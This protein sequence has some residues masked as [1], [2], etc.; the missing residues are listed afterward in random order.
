[1]GS[2]TVVGFFFLRL[3]CL[4]KEGVHNILP[5]KFLCFENVFVLLCCHEILKANFWASHL[6]LQFLLRFDM[7]K[8]SKDTQVLVLFMFSDIFWSPRI[9]CQ[10]PLTLFAYESN[11]CKPSSGW[12]HCVFIT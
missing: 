11:D 3:Y 7:E 6:F 5:I 1:M 9:F 8:P 10:E 4:T 12:L 2:S